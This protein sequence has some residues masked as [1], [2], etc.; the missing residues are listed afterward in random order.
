MGLIKQSSLEDNRKRQPLA[1]TEFERVLNLANETREPYAQRSIYPASIYD[2]KVHEFVLDYFFPQEGIDEFKFQMY[3][4]HGKAAERVIQHRLFL[5]GVL[6]CPHLTF[7]ETT[8]YCAETGISGRTDGIIWVEKIKALGSKTP[9]P[10]PD[11]CR[12]AILEIKETSNYQFS[13]IRT[14]DDVPMKYRWAQCAY[15][16]ILGIPES[17]FLYVNRDSMNLKTMFYE[18]DDATWEQIQAKCDLIWAHIRNRTIPFPE[19]E[20]TVD[21]YKEASQ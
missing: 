11:E 18:S 9:K 10:V 19:G 12:R 7:Q 16:R 1:A 6:D 21:E 5:A 17:C 8:V 2:K 15:Q 20:M 4:S 14:P 13:N 3:V